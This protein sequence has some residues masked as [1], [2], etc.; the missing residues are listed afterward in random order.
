[1]ATGFNSLP[2]E[3]LSARYSRPAR[4][5]LSAGQSPLPITCKSSRSLTSHLS[6]LTALAASSALP[7]LSGRAGN[8][9]PAETLGWPGA[10]L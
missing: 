9:T 10:S 7:A 3:F 6:L 1:M 8:S 4:V 5:S 2:H